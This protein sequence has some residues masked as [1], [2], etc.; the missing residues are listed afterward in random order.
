M[1]YCMGNLA[2]IPF[3]AILTLFSAVGAKLHDSVSEVNFLEG[4]K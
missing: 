4:A 1:P 2:G 3:T